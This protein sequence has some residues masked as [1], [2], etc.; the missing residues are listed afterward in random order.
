M[1]VFIVIA[2]EDSG[3]AYN[4]YS[5]RWVAYAGID[6]AKAREAY[7]EINNRNNGRLSNL[8][9]PYSAE[10]EEWVNGVE[11]DSKDCVIKD[12]F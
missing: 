2:C 4:S 3:G 6:E 1:R 11:V 5:H 8:D 12:C 9:R 7:A 10:I